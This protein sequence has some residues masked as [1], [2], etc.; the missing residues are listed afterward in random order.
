MFGSPDIMNYH[1]YLVKIMK[2]RDQNDNGEEY[3]VP[4]GLTMK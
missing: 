2:Q 3:R 1:Q 4:A